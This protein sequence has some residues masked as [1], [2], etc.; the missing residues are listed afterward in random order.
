MNR[1][2]L[3]LA[4]LA[5]FVA[6]A[7]A[8]LVLIRGG[9]IVTNTPQGILEAD[10]LL[11][12]DRVVTVG[13]DLPSS[14]ATVIEAQGRWVTPGVFAAMSHI[15]LSDISGSGAPND[16][17]VSGALVSAAADVARAFNPSAA[18]IAVTRMEGVTRA[19]IAP[20]SSGSMFDGR[21]ALVVLDGRT[22]AVFAPRAFQVARMGEEGADRTGG[23]RAALW[24]AFEAA[25]ADARSY[26]A[27]YVSGRG[28]AVLGELD[29][30]ALKPFA[31]GQG[32]LLI[33]TDRASDIREALRFKAANPKMRMAIYGAAEGWLVARELAAAGVAVIVDPLANLPARLETLAARL[34][35]A[36]LLH[37]AGV[38]VAIA[39]GP[40]RVDG[41]QARLAPQLAG[42]AVAHGMPWDA[43][44]A[45]ISRVPAEIFGVDQRVGALAPGRLADV[46]IW[47]GD[48]LDVRSAPV[49][50]FIEGRQTPLVSR[51]TALRDR[52]NPARR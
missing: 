3:A 41:N 32:L 51:Q 16:A 6:P 48:P 50:V 4:A 19:A 1:I 40:D 36:A 38:K 26:P 23:S 34:D 44:F 2:L 27:R 9:K 21:G 42:N 29:A 14:G 17:T 33:H 5:L 22:E 45:A 12:D 49:A 47:D 11:R 43:A 18:S 10:V 35:N 7:S 13:R 39:P 52:Y 30:A 28:G 20:E 15:G 24:P 37:A 31:E 8:E 46:V 25:L